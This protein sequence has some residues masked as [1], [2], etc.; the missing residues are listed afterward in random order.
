MTVPEP[1]D[2]RSALRM[3]GIARRAGELAVGSEAVRRGIRA[4]ELALVVV[5]RDAGENAR[6][7]V[8][9]PAETGGVP[10]LELGTRSSLGRALGRSATVTVGVSDG[11]LAGAVREKARSDDAPAAD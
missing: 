5:A 9:P 6:G 8:V 2:D 4:G 1:P 10:V 11:G 3:L 7:R